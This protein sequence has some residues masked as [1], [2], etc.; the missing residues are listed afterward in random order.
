MSNEVN[1][2][3]VDKVLFM[4]KIQPNYSNPNCIKS[5]CHSNYSTNNNYNI[6]NRIDNEKP[7][8]N[9]LQGFE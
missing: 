8:L 5:K 6:G 7:W 2:R 4:E 1:N 3:V 9:N